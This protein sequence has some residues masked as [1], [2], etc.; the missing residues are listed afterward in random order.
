MLNKSEVQFESPAKGMQHCIACTHY[1][2]G[3]CEIVRGEVLPGDWCRL[4][5][6]RSPMTV[7]QKSPTQINKEANDAHECQRKEA[8]AR[9][10]HPGE[11]IK[12]H[13]LKIPS[14]TRPGTTEITFGP[15][16]GGLV[17][18]NPFSS[19]AQAGYLH[20]HP[21]KLGKKGL[22]EWDAATKGKSLPEH[23]KKAK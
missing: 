6:K 20:S 8:D 14:R 4:F 18:A 22:D 16:G 5:Q 12:E 19:I 13:G 17:P 21:E 1:I 2:A 3:R 15:Q 7:I 23:V 9:T 11:G 10:N